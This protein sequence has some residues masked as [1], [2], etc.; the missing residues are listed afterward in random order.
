MKIEI[1]ASHK[2]SITIEIWDP[3]G[4]KIDNTLSCNTTKEFI[5]ETFWTVPQEIVPGTYTI[6]V[7]DAISSD[8]ATFEVIPRL[9][10]FYF[11]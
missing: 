2:T 7:N 4:N 9:K 6:K 11:T 8:Q 3:S 5:C 1:T 10:Q